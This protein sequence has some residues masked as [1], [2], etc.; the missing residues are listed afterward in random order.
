MRIL[1]TM[2]TGSHSTKKR[3]ANGGGFGEKK[4][5]KVKKDT[6]CSECRAKIT[7]VSTIISH[8]DT[9][10][11]QCSRC[12]SSDLFCQ[13]CWAE[14]AGSF[15]GGDCKRFFCPDCHPNYK[16]DDVGE[17]YCR[18]SCAPRGTRWDT[19]L[20]FDSDG[21]DYD[22]DEDE[23]AEDE[24]YDNK[25]FRNLSARMA[26]SH[27]ATAGGKERPLHVASASCNG[28]RICIYCRKSK[29][30]RSCPVRQCP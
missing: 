4:A 13:E 20:A 21:D 22:D 18:K 23:D 27:Q 3:G 24:K 9:V 16:Y 29:C 17:M 11:Y 26:S 1:Y 19:S 10:G 8:D 7:S 28:N 30:S 15:C 6:R 14:V 2:S 5:K 12:D 25:F